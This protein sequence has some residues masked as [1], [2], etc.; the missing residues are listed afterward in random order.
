MRR[1]VADVVD[2]LERRLGGFFD[3]RDRLA[4]QR[5]SPRNLVRV[6]GRNELTCEL[7]AARRRGRGGQAL[8]EGRKLERG[9]GGFVHAPSLRGRL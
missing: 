7:L 8:D 2:S 5:L 9:E 3:E 6:A 4:R 1:R